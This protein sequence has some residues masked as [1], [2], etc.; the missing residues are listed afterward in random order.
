MPKAQQGKRVTR[1][2]KSN[3]NNSPKI[4]GE[5]MHWEKRVA[6]QQEKKLVDL[7]LDVTLND[8]GKL[9][10]NCLGI[11]MGKRPI[12][13][14]FLKIAKDIADSLIQLEG[15]KLLDRK[16]VLARIR[17]FNKSY[18]DAYKILLHT[19][20]GTNEN[21]ESIEGNDV[22]NTNIDCYFLIIMYRSNAQ[23]LSAIS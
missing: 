22:M 9:L 7:S 14:T 6:K 17:R 15:P 20:S 13:V 23:N 2:N 19:D 3:E 5:Y 8:N 12:G 16:A 21:G 1:Y 4:R 18:K 10:K 11:N